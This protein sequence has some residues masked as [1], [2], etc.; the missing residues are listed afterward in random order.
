MIARAT[1]VAPRAEPCPLHE[2]LGRVLAEPVTSPA[3]LPPFD[4]AAMDG[5]ALPLEAETLPAGHELEVRGERAAGDP[6][7]A[8]RTA[9]EIMT[10]APV[11]DGLGA[12]IPV[13]QVEVL[14]ADAAG[15]PTRIRLGAEVRAGQHV[16]R[17]GEDLARGAVAL[18]AGTRV[19]A[20][21]LMLLAGL[22]VGRPSV[23]PRPRVALLCTGRELVDDPDAPLAS[24][25]I[26]NN[27]A[28]YLRARIT[29]A[30]AELVL[31]RTVSDDRDALR[32]ALDAALDAGAEVVV[33]TGAVSMG[34]YDFVPDTLDALGAETVFHKVKMRPGKPLLFAQLEA[35]GALFFGLPGNPVSSAVGFRFFVEPAL[36][37]RLGLPEERP[38]RV[39]LASAY[40]KKPGFRVFTKARVEVGEGAQLRVR[41]LP[42][43]ESFKVSPLAHANAWAVLPEGAERLDAGDAVEVCGLGHFGFELETS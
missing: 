29:A 1:R 17:A 10:G 4:N 24:G 21:Q 23:R 2:A 6:E 15:L 27:N 26:R 5:F 28:P 40:A 31:Y 16:R 13:E 22:G 43:Q 37:A 30:G 20:A 36:R 42:G 32:A 34:K 38:L 18:E 8:Q 41:V 3:D 9:C 39:P 14:A 19:G 25:Q 33:T 11:P 12:V 7:S 35:R